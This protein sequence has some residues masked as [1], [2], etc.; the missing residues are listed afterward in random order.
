MMS[1]NN[2]NPLTAIHEK[3]HGFVASKKIPHLLFHG[4]PGSGKRTLVY[5]FINHIYHG[6]RDS[7][8][9]WVMYVNCSQQGK[10][11][12]F[13][14]DDLKLFAKINLPIQGGSVFKTIVLFNADKL[15]MEAQSALRR[16]IELFSH[17]TRFFI[18]AEEKYNLMKPILSRF[19]EIFVPRQQNRYQQQIQ[20]IWTDVP[21]VLPPFP[22]SLM[23]HDALE[24]YV[25][26]L[27]EQGISCLDLFS[28]TQDPNLLFRFQTIRREFRNEKMLM[29]AF[30]HSLNHP[31][32][33]LKTIFT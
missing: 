25:D 30:L 11:I 2:N 1:S 7:I 9:K 31:P 8:F 22:S 3:L 18:V 26:Q 21:L 14:R 24:R 23:D 4:E 27:Y 15:T 28:L 19:C 17:N 32:L 20:Q 13:I 6:D 33:Q 5:S 10:G 16:C 12:K 29:Y